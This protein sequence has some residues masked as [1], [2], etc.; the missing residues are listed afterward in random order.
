V[1]GAWKQANQCEGKVRIL[2]DSHAELT[3]ALGVKVDLSAPFGVTGERCKRFSAYVVDGEIKIW[4]VEPDGTGLS[5]SLSP[6]LLT[7]I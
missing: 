6:S 7:Q 3:N 2:A 1:T 4:N 5:C